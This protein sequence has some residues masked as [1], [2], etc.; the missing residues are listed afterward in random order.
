MAPMPVFV[1]IHGKQQQNFFGRNFPLILL[2]VLIKYKMSILNAVL[3]GFF[4]SKS[5]RDLKE[6]TPT[7][8]QIRAV[9]STLQGLSNDEL[10]G[11]TDNLRSVIKARTAPIE[12]EILEL[13]QKMED[14]NVAYHEKE[15]IYNQVEKLTKE[16]DKSIEE[17]LTEILPEAFAVMKDTA[18]R[19]TENKE[20]VVTAN[21][22]DRDLAATR[23][24][25]T[26]DGD[27]AIYHNT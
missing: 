25:V 23:D 7:L 5:D 18:R 20:I 1:F 6:V 16:L 26:I 8:E 11:R 9:Y 10:R 27:K 14:D 2:S 21:A 12:N 13:K 17:V 24:F 15:T 19:F 22:F 3:K 4:G